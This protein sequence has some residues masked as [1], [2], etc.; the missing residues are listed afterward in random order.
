MELMNSSLRQCTE[1]A[2]VEAIYRAQHQQMS[3]TNLLAVLK[4][5]AKVLLCLE[6]RGALC[7][8]MPCLL[9]AARYP[10]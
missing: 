5:L 7:C 9:P 8:T 2:Q 6:C 1:W 4:Q 10:A 3:T